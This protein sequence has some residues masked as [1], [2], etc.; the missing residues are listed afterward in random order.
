MLRLAATR[1]LCG[2]CS[3]STTTTSLAE[4]SGEYGDECRDFWLEQHDCEGSDAYTD[5]GLGPEQECVEFTGCTATTRYCL[6]AAEHG[7]QIGDY[8]AAKRWPSSQL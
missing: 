8:Y 4:L 7:H 3:A 5:L 2:P 6:Y 1:L